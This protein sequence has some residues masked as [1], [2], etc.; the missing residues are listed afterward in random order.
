MM[1]DERYPNDRLY[2]WFVERRSIVFIIGLAF[3]VLAGVATFHFYDHHKNTLRKFLKEDRATAELF[4]LLLEEHLDKI[5]GTMTSYANRPLLLQAV[6]EENARTAREHLISLGATS[7]GIDILVI[8]DKQGR[9]WAS[10]PRRTEIHGMSF[11]RDDW[12]RGVSRGWKP[13]VSDI[14]LGVAGEKDA[15]VHIA[16]PLFDEKGEVIGILVSTQRVV[17]L[18]G[19][20][21]R[22]P[23]E[24]EAAISI[25]D[26][27]RNIVYGN[28]NPVIGGL[29][30][31]PFLSVFNAIKDDEERFF[32]VSDGAGR[33]KY[34]SFAPVTSIGWYVFVD[35]DQRSVFFSE[36]EHYLQTF[37]ITFLL[38]LIISI[39]LLYF[40]KQVITRQ[41]MDRLLAE[42]NLRES[43]IRFRELFDTMNSG[44]VVCKVTPDGEDFIIADLNNAAQ[45]ITGVYEDFMG[46]NVCDIFPG[47]K[48]MGLFGVFQRVWRTGT[49]EFH[50]S[51]FYTDEC[52][53]FWMETNVY[54]LP[55]GEVIAIFDDVTEQ[56][57][58][59]EEIKKLNEGLEQMVAD[60]TLQL[61]VAN[62]ELEAFC[63]SVSHDLRSPLRAI[64][65]FSQALLE[66]CGERVDDQGKDYL[67]R[68]RAASQRMAQLIDDLLR[69]SRISRKDMRDETVDLSG[70]TSEILLDLREENPGRTV[71]FYVAEG[72]TVRGDSSLLGIAIGNLLGNAYKFTR[73]SQ[74]ARIEFGAVTQEGETVYFVRDNGV[75]FDMKYADKLFGAFQRLH[76]KNEFEGTGIGLATVKRVMHRHGGRVWAEAQVGQGATFY[77][78]IQG[79]GM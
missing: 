51:S 11:A 25:V 36:W 46:K 1:K 27:N 73:G 66:D 50:P 10:Q 49:A 4:S 6:R 69:L 65:G 55:S 62:R 3:F 54:I 38:F 68:V 21:K 14:A 26:R 61:E 60:R 20:V 32:T 42:N 24:P 47:I 19:F 12:Y 45:K 56:K 72:I 37:L 77:F 71:E 39:S 34:V 43:E 70:L 35:R 40:R 23:L 76:P 33:K 67:A 44:V 17:G 78:T 5:I 48:E 30:P 53:S 57:R 8:A 29:A 28:L 22:L 18:Q 59:E 58:A 52:V 63:Y 9:V 7:R 64:D 41:T 79:Q 13:Y 15:A 75:G 16:V 2:P 31:Y 74:K